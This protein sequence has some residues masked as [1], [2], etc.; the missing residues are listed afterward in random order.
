[1]VEKSKLGIAAPRLIKTTKAFNRARKGTKHTK[2][3]ICIAVWKWVLFDKQTT[4]NGQLT[5]I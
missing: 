5:A 1:M 3:T 4:N 2:S